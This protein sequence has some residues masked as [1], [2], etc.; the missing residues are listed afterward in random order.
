MVSQGL[1]IKGVEPK[2]TNL[3]PRTLFESSSFN[4]TITYLTIF[5]ILHFMYLMMSMTPQ[6]KCLMNNLGILTIY[7]KGFNNL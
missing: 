3:L 7:L 6:I 1:S 4:P 2:L 5:K